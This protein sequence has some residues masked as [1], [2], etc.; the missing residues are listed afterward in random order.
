MLG[1]DL[2]FG[3]FLFK[4]NRRQL[5]HGE[6][7]VRLGSRA[8]AILEALLET[9][10]RLVPRTELYERAWPGRTVNEANLK[11]QISGLRKALANYG[12]LIRAES[13]LGYRFVGDT[14][15]AFDSDSRVHPPARRSPP[16]LTHAP[17]GRDNVIDRIIGL[18]RN[19]RLVTILG[20][21]G[22]GKTTVALAVADQLVS[23]YPDGL[24]IVEL[25]RIS[26]ESQVYATVSATL[27]LPVEVAANIDQ[28][29]LALHGRRFLL[30]LDSC[31][32]LTERVAILAERVLEETRDVH[33]LVTSRESLRIGSETIWR[34]DPLE[35]PPASLQ[36]T[37]ASIQNYSSV[38][39]FERTARQGAIDFEI[40]DATAATVADICRHLDGIPLAIEL[41]ASMVDVLGIDQVC[42]G[43]NQRFSLLKTDRRTANLRH[44]SLAATIDWSYGLLPAGEQAVLRRL[45][46]F[47]RPFT[48]HAATEVAK[49]GEMDPA[50]VR[51]AVVALANKSFLSLN[52]QSTPFE[53]RLLETMR[54]YASQ[55]ERPKEERARAQERHARYFLDQLG[56]KDWDQ[57]EPAAE[58]ARMRSYIDEIRTALDWAF[59]TDP[60]LAIK[61]VLAA[62][63]LWLELTSLAQGVP[64]LTKALRHVESKEE[65]EPAIKAR[66][67]I[68]LASAQVYVPGHERASL[69]DNAW[70]AAQTARDDFLELRALYGIIQNRLLTRRPATR[71]VDAFA[72]ASQR[73]GDPVT[74]RLFLRISAFHDLELSDVKT[75]VRRFEAF[76][77]DPAP[78]P[79]SRYLY[80][81]GFDS[82][83][84]CKVGLALAKHLQGY[85]DQARTLLASAVSEAEGLGHITTRYFVLAQ[86]AI[87]Q[88]ISSGDFQLANAYLL[89]L[90]E[91]AAHYRPWHVVIDVFQ[92]LLLR[93]ETN[94]LRT[95]EQL[96]AFS[97]QDPF[98]KKTGTLH[99]VMWIELADMRRRLG[100]IDGAI[101]AVQ[102]AMTQ[103][104]GDQDARLIGKYNPVFA[105]I[106]MAR[107]GAGDRDA[108]RTLFENAIDLSRSHDIY[109]Y[110]C[111]ATVGFAE[112][113]LAAGH[114]RPAHS[115]L[116]RLLDR[117]G[118][119]ERVPGIAQAKK[120]L[121]EAETALRDLPAE[122]ELR[123]AGRE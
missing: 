105:K 101:I 17:I 12:N 119:R 55:A 122:P 38:K 65:I 114:P 47:A 48:L 62:E 108:A 20:T 83:I 8:R 52:D 10:G 61:L 100:D 19:H 57:Y 70:Q 9:P 90:E 121:D 95:A 81:G 36:A 123:S 91:V 39:L 86:G 6:T 32:H 106:L 75:A 66:V 85:C 16:H 30:I 63:R 98:M 113:E 35:I 73:A 56:Y 92:A 120:L 43:L 49:E 34:L 77:D 80:L 96:M 82:I 71:Y 44:R 45:S 118:D 99:P 87:W 88:N 64:H 25:D 24:R 5:W 41:A 84:S 11:V 37:A 7:L 104:L 14:F 67:L 13:S 27:D 58:G 53:Y 89:K 117:L 68:A 2:R 111:E 18:L 79:R 60:D 97:L 31:E 29:L 74:Q 51:D 21:G 4:R 112:L 69:Y 110:E 115:A 26:D 116:T 59:A 28:V 72:A 54:A 78:I 93:D 46:V 23:A 76:L 40:S 94:D 33:I 22:I 42:R 3:P 107:D 109:L 102:Q 103:F 15:A 50:A 1:P